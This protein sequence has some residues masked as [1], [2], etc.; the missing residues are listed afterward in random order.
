MTFKKTA[1]AGA[2]AQIALLA[3]SAAWAQTASDNTTTV[4]VTGQR[5]ALQ[6][7]QKLKQNADEVVDSIVAEDIGKLPDRSVTEVLQ[8]IAGVTI[9]RNMAGDPNRQSV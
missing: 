3:T 5:A 2:I 4:V 1:I 7:A 8:R 6:S 9:D